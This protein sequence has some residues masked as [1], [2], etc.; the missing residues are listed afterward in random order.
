MT[1]LKCLE[2]GRRNEWGDKRRYV[3][4]EEGKKKEGQVVVLFV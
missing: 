1:G 3:E 4:E 2:K